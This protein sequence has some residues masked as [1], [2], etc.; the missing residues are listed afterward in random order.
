MNN[1]ANKFTA[2]KQREF[3]YEL[4]VQSSVKDEATVQSDLNLLMNSDLIYRQ[5]RVQGENYIFYYRRY[6]LIQTLDN[7]TLPLGSKL[8]VAPP[9]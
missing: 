3:S 2:T 1:N 8:I 6:L 9:R 7:I 4:L 5:R